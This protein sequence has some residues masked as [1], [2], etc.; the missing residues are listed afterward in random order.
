MVSG[1]SNEIISGASAARCRRNS[2]FRPT[3]A[4]RSGIGSATS[5]K[6]IY[7][8]FEF[9]RLLKAH[10]AAAGREDVVFAIAE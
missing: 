7:F 6:K 3:W 8:T 5:Q 10:R 2:T 4:T 9:A 1:S